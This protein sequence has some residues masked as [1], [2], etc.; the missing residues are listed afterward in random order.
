M[1]PR[2]RDNPFI[3]F[4]R[5]RKLS[6]LGKDGKVQAALHVGQCGGDA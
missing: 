6:R 3:R 2:N 5:S 1:V 4:H